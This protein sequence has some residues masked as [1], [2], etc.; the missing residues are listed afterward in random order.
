VSIKSILPHPSL[1]PIGNKT[2]IETTNQTFMIW[3]IMKPWG[4][5]SVAF[6]RH[7]DGDFTIWTPIDDDHKV[8][9]KK[10]ANLLGYK[11]PGDWAKIDASL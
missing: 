3:D 10:F 2:E 4:I 9:N 6:L 5:T 7:D 8:C 11:S 1:P